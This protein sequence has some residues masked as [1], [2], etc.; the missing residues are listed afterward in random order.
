MKALVDVCHVYGIA[1]FLDVVYNHAGGGFDDDSIYFLDRQPTVNNNSSLYFTGQG[2]VGGLV[3]AYWNADV[4][5]FLINNAAFYATST[6]STAS[7][8]TR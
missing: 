2:Y 7:A 6:T 4:R 1:V 5:Q 8:T 3:F